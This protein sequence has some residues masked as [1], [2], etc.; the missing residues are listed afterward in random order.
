M[1]CVDW[2]HVPTL[3]WALRRELALP[4]AVAQPDD[5][6]PGHDDSAEMT[7]V[8][9]TMG[10]YG[11]LESRKNERERHWNGTVHTVSALGTE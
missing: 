7:H 8:Q 2:P 5:H 10:C 9:P 11:A 4:F 3:E 6:D 1:R